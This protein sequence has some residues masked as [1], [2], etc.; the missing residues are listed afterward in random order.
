VAPRRA[1]PRVVAITASDS[2]WQ[3]AAWLWPIANHDCSGPRRRSMA[4]RSGPRQRR[5]RM[6]VADHHDG[7]TA[8]QADRQPGRP[9]GPPSYE[10]ERLLNL[11]LEAQ[12]RSA[13]PLSRA[14]HSWGLHAADS[15]TFKS[16]SRLPAP[17]PGRPRSSGVSVTVLIRVG[18]CVGPSARA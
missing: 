12:S 15:L 9:A 5:T 18:R 10:S 2:D 17:R 6:A 13:E 14:C 11:N 7:R 3:R 4:R 8:A 16:R 1:G